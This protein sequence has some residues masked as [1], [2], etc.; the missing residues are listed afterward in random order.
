MGSGFPELEPLEAS[1]LRDRIE[2]RIR[3]AILTGAFGPGERLIESAIADHLD[4]SR[5]PVREA[6]AA[7]DREG[8]VV[9]VPR[10]GFFVID[11]TDKDLEEIYS[12]RLLL[13]REA[14]RRAIERFTE[15]DIRQ[16]QDILNE[17]GRATVEKHEP[18]RI[19][20]LDLSFHDCICRMADHSRLYA[21]WRSTST[22]AQVLVGLTSKTHY[23]H[24]EEPRQLH[25]VILEAIR[26]HDLPLA[27]ECLTNHILDAQ[28]R[29]VMALT[30][31]R[32]E[33]VE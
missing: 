14:L 22:Q 3:N 33:N 5:G 20:E 12:L 4:V 19:V 1:N 25:Q 32:Q 15:E 2:L 31:L 28:Q 24:P 9:H 21:A 18:E 13:E 6:L 30:L 17:L 10:K 16:M 27:E 26:T 7:L 11:F 29:A 8:I 23:N